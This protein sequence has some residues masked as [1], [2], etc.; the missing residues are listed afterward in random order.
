MSNNKLFHYTDGT[1]LLGILK[2]KELWLTHIAF[3]NDSSELHY[4]SGVYKGVLG[5]TSKSEATDMK[6]HAEE[7]LHWLNAR[8]G[9][10]NLAQINQYLASFSD[11]EDDLGQWRGYSTQGARYCIEFDREKLNEL[12]GKAGL[13]LGV[14]E[15]DLVRAKS[16]IRD[17]FAET[18]Q[19]T[20]EEKRC[21]KAD[22]GKYQSRWVYIIAS[23]RVLERIGPWIKHEKFASEKEWRLVASG[24]EPVVDR[25]RHRVG[26]SFLVPHMSLRIDPNDKPITG[27]WI[28][29]SAHPEL[30]MES[31]R[32][33]V[34]AQGWGQ[35]FPEAYAS[36]AIALRQSKVPYRDW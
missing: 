34:Y 8:S 22:N 19:H 3:L 14:V 18:L 28:G 12:A 13:T 6:V 7:A 15:Y 24:H 2:T 36:N 9:Y 4:T 21:A 26:R 29:P 23:E 17:V 1:G 11:S 5:E 10:P 35:A 30:A 33:L 27:I 20:A 16:R 32:L 31:L 25:V